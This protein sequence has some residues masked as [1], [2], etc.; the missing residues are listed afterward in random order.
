MVQVVSI[1]RRAKTAIERISNERLPGIYQMQAN[2]YDAQIGII[3]D[4]VNVL[5]ELYM[6]D[7]AHVNTNGLTQQVAY[8]SK[9][10]GDLKKCSADV[11]R[12]L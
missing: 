4:I 7:V 10:I 11:R 3:E 9:E 12:K 8:L 5:N 1:E 2:L 6:K